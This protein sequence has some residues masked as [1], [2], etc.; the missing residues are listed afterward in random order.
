MPSRCSDAH[1]ELAR[2]AGDEVVD[3]VSGSTDQV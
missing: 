3:G 1:A 2:D